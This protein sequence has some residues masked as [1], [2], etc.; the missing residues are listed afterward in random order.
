MDIQAV[1]REKIK[2]I[3]E[4]EQVR[5]ILAVESGSRAW[6][7]E[8]PDSDYDVRFIYVRSK[9]DYLK[10]EEVRDVIEWQLD[11]TLDISG[12]D[13]QK[14]L[15]LLYKSNPTLF[16]W[17]ASPIIYE[18]KPEANA[19]RKLIQAYF[20][21]QKLVYHYWNMA[22]RNYCEYLQHDLVKSKKY[23]YVLRPILAGKWVLTQQTPPPMEF[24]KLVES[25]LDEN[26]KPI[27]AEL[28]AKKRQV[29]EADLV[30]KIP[31]L[32]H[33]I[34]EKLA[35]L[36]TEAKKLTLQKNEWQPLNAFFLQLLEE[37][38]QL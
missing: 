15:R 36:E 26:L 32:N 13:I 17:C 23:F 25:E 24:E 11:D 22:K 29:G 34:E 4:Q 35:W 18:E 5:I 27:V 21:E 6:G 8:S 7:F 31:L 10:L 19:L 2:E 38:N 37:N 33:Y 9:N 16:E 20:S 1:I 30:P 28:I 14:A 3:E 12:W